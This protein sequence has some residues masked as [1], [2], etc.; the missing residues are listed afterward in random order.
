MSLAVHTRQHRG[1]A[2][3]KSQRKSADVLRGVPFGGDPLEEARE[4]MWRAYPASS[5]DAC[6]KRAAEDLGTSRTVILDILAKRTKN[7]SYPLLRCALERIDDPW[8]MP[9]IRRFVQRM[10]ARG[11]K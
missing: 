1:E 7:P 6:A 11:A 2:S 10:M 5:A 9:A 3:R 4:I 8:E